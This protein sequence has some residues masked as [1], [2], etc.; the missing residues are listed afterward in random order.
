MTERTLIAWRSTLAGVLAL[1]AAM[2][3]LGPALAQT[4]PTP[5]PTPT[6]IPRPAPIITTTD[7]R[8]TLALYFNVLPQGSAGVAHIPAGEV[9]GARMRFL[10]SVTDFYSAEDGL[11]VLVPIGLDVVP[12]DYPLTVSVLYE[13]GT[14]GTL[15]ATVNVT[16]GGFVRQ[17]FSVP[18]ERAYLTAP[19]VE[20]NE[21]ARISS[22]FERSS[23]VRLWDNAGFQQPIDSEI[24]SPFGAFRT[25]NQNTQ[26]RH[27]GWDLRAAPGTPIQASAT[28]RIAFAGP[29][30]IRGNCI[31]IDHGFGVFSAYAH[32]SQIHVSPGQ[33]VNHGQIIGVTGN[34]GRSNGPH[35]HWEIAVNGEWVD[36]LAFTQMWL[37]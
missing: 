34:T 29:L 10:G 7:G 17:A 11:Y 36:S 15:D 4:D 23:D 25:L 22:V 26:T 37:P 24:T 16:G 33:T 30:D 5:E 35:L 12:R 2:L 13:D 31:I 3:I 6:P 19:E 14:R 9:A 1:L 21:Y 18:A 8:S 27:T 32:L 28:G 20:R